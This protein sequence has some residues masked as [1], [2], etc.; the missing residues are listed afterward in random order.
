MKR[1]PRVSTKRVRGAVGIPTP[2]D[3]HMPPAAVGVVGCGTMGQIITSALVRT[4]YSVVVHDTDPVARVAAASAGATP[5]SDL[6][7]LAACPVVTLALPGPKEVREVVLGLLGLPR[8]PATILDTSTSDPE[9]TRELASA[10]GHRET[11]LL[12]AP[13]LGRPAT[14]GHWTV[15]VGGDAAALARVRP[16]LEAFAA[17]VVHV[18]PAGAAHT[19]KLLNQMMFA[20]INAATAEVMALAPRLGLA[21]SL[22]YDTVVSS[23]AATVSGLF[24]ELGRKISREDFSPVFSVG[25]LCKDTD[26][27]ME[28]ARRAGGAAVMTSTVQLLNHLAWAWGLSGQDSSALFHVYRRLGGQTSGGGD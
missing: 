23:G 24:R 12:D 14:V 21:P 13:I 20:I 18:G 9:T 19:L 25:L 27:A 5:A 7:A 17:R 16:V 3:R 22:F 2:L 6:V 28:M 15:A 11:A 4:G 1:Q 26:L 8:P 10:A